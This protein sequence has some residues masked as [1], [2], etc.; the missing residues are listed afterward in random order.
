MVIPK[1]ILKMLGVEHDDVVLELKKA[2]HIDT[3]QQ[4]AVN[5]FFEKLEEFSFK[6]LGRASE[7]LG[8]QVVYDDEHGYD[9]DQE[10]MILETR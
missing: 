7:F 1:E 10:V 4:S 9:L 8:M 2:F 3:Q 5:A 6:D